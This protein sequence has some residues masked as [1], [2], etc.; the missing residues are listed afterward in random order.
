MEWSTRLVTVLL[1]RHGGSVADEFGENRDR[2]FAVTVEPINTYAVVGVGVFRDLEHIGRSAVVK[3]HGQRSRGEDVVGD[4]TAPLPGDVVIC[5]RVG[6]VC[7]AGR[8]QNCNRC[9]PRMFHATTLTENPR[10]AFCIMTRQIKFE[11]CARSLSAGAGRLSSNLAMPAYQVLNLRSSGRPG[12]AAQ[13]LSNPKG[14]P[15]N[16]IAKLLSEIDGK[17]RKKDP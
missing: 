9:K 13:Y 17:S 7:R 2:L 14:G 10:A 16:V 3:F 6:D 1:L 11:S 5:R 12:A 4:I 15:V 8:K